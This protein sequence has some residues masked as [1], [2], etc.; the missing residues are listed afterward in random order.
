MVLVLS[1]GVGCRQILGIDPGV[2]RDDAAR[3]DMLGPAD[4]DVGVDVP[5]DAPVDAL[6]PGTWTNITLVPGTSGDQDPTL[7]SDQLEMY[8]TRGGSTILSMT[9]ATITSAWSAADVQTFG[10]SPVVINHSPELSADGL[11]IAFSSNRGGTG[12]D[13]YL[14]SR[15]SRT[16]A[17]APPVPFSDLNS[18]FDEHPGSAT[19]D[20]ARIVLSSNRGGSGTGLDLFESTGNSGTY[21]P[22]VRIPLSTTVEDS[23]PFLTNDGLTL[24]YS[25]GVAANGLDLHVATRPDRGAAFTTG[26]KIQ[27]LT[28]PGSGETDPWVSPDGHDLYFAADRGGGMRIYHASR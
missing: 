10:G 15:L 19:A 4:A 27:E 3:D 12:L 13:I 11:L 23:A 7:T 22:P 28:D 14:A 25:S 17:W 1:L 20:L 2:V 18:T 16:S 26:T 21:T 5:N 8:F 6:P 9:R 24:Y